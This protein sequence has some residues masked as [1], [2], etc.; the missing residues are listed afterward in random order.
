VRAGGHTLILLANPRVLPILRSLA[1][2][3]RGRQDLRRAAGFPA[4]ST[5]R[6]Q[7]EALEGLGVTAKQRPEVF[8]GAYEYDLTPVGAELLEVADA[9][10]RWLAQAPRGPLDL[11]SDP[12]RAAIKG[13]VDGWFARMLAPMAARPLSLTE[14][15]QE[16][17]V[18]YPTLERR[19]EAMRLN[20][21]VE[22]VER[23]R[24]GTPYTPTDWLRRG[25]APLAIAARWEHRNRPPD[26]DPITRLEIESAIRIV[27]DLVELPVQTSGICQLS[28]RMP[29]GKRSR[30]LGV[31][32]IEEGKL[33]FG[34]AY[35]QR[36]PDAWASGN[37]E[38]WFS[39]VIDAKARGMRLS[40]N[41]DLVRAV[42]DGIR[43]GLLLADSPAGAPVF[44][45]KN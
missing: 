25:I 38:Q 1:E 27:A 45:N 43:H 23:D 37:V 15:D 30:A 29:E 4:Q 44:P 6:S 19:L 22:E 39:L 20:E 7:L 42:F 33:A 13:L 21:Q 32:E 11:G 18:S 3:T 41:R 26:A 16:V 36:K 5:L 14:L 31:I 9:L 2:G 17:A 35:P 40:G 8:P 34:G 24:G 12:G 28:V 10:E